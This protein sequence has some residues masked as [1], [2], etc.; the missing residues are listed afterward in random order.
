ML[1]EG[2]GGGGFDHK[3]WEVGIWLFCGVWIRLYIECSMS[4]VAG[5]QDLCRFS[6]FSWHVFYQTVLQQLYIVTYP[7]LKR[8]VWRRRQ[9]LRLC[10]V[11]GRWMCVVCWWNDIDGGRMS[12]RKLPVSLPICPPQLLHGLAWKFN[13]AVRGEWSATNGLSRGPKYTYFILKITVYLSSKILLSRA[14]NWKKRYETNEIE[15]KEE[16]K[17]NMQGTVK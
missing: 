11:D 14:R 3:R 5:E 15:R 1:G 9:L 17:N 13:S 10:S 12:T 2:G 8:A 6:T 4:Y 7:I 16:W